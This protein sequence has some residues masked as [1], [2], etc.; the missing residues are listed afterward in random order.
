MT[1]ASVLAL[2]NF[3]E[4]FVVEV[5]ASGLG[6]G[7]VLSQ[8]N[9]LIAFLSQALSPKHLG[10]STYEKELIALLL[11]V[12]KWPLYLPPNHFEIQ[13]DHLSLKFLRD[14]RIT[15]SLQHNG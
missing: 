5:D 9:S 1:Q 11:A 8:H 4:L 3:T 10:M 7:A 13:T 12:E 2:P 15:T 14:Q 6:V